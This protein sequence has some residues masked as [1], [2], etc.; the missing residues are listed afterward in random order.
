MSAKYYIYWNLHR[1]CYSVK[2]RGKVVRHFHNAHVL[3]P[4]FRVSAKGR[5]RVRREGAK[6]VHAYIVSDFIDVQP[7][8]WP[9]TKGLSFRGWRLGNQIATYNPYKNESFVDSEGN[10]LYNAREAY[11]GIDQGK[12]VIK[13]N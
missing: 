6:N 10:A 12:P 9:T 5:E 1:K 8:Y 7:S 4:E 13:F 11:L 3:L 2:H